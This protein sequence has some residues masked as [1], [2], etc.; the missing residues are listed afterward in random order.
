MSLKRGSKCGG[1]TGGRSCG[2]P[3]PAGKDY[4]D[5][6]VK[7]RGQHV[8]SHEME[9]HSFTVPMCVLCERLMGLR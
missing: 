5:D 6:C 2:E 8:T 1:L 4:C 7:L 9:G 3:L